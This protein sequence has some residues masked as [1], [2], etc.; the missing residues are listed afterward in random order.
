MR[1]ILLIT[2]A[3]LLAGCT[4]QGGYT[5]EHASA[6][7]TRL[8]QLK[9]AGEWEMGMQAFQAGDLDKALKRVDTAIA[10]N[11]SVARS[12][13][14]RG[15][16]LME[17]G[18]IGAALESLGRAVAIDPDH[19]EGHY[20]SGIAYERLAQ[21]DAALACYL[22]AAELDRTN[23]QYA[24]AAAEMYMDLGRLE[25]A[26]TFL[27]EQNE[28]FVHHAGVKQTM[29][30]LAML[31]GDSAGAIAAFSEARLLA[32]DDRA[33]LE[34]L[35]RAQYAGAQYAKAEST[36]AGL[37]RDER[38]EGRRDLQLLHARC[39]T[40]LKRPVEAREILIKLTMG[41]EGAGDIDAWIQLGH[42]SY[43]L[44]D[45]GRVRTAAARLTA[46]APERPE[47]FLLKGLL[48]R[49]QGDLGQALENCEKSVALGEATGAGLLLQGMLLD[50]LGRLA[51]ARAA[52]SKAAE[53][54]PANA[55]LA[56]MIA[57]LD[58][59]IAS[60]SAL[61]EVPEDSD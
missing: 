15:R 25:E 24:V 32:P 14:L 45:L 19:V 22:R 53:A 54:D 20:Y 16:I 39:L 21:R 43:A 57:S 47:G 51:D 4:G 49:K 28:L 48:L 10:L 59:R 13:V 29:G 33:I 2:A 26:G 34:D 40:Q 18:N 11:E 35:A 55:A 52:Y 27:G 44:K 42:V 61:A 58:A 6:A 9:S 31:K 3:A 41:S 30:H 7:R 17:K 23:A 50:E 37:L 5:R 46:M 36:L 12:H 60:A 8:D 1:T 56:K 38:A